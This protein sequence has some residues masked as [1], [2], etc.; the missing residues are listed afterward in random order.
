VIKCSWHSKSLTFLPKVSVSSLTVSLK[1]FKMPDKKHEC[2]FCKKDFQSFNQ[3]SIHMRSHTKESPWKCQICVDEKQFKISSHYY[4]HMRKHDKDKPQVPYVQKLRCT[5]FLFI[6]S[7]SIDVEFVIKSFG[8][9]P[10][11]RVMF[12]ITQ[13][14]NHFPVTFASEWILKHYTV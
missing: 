2:Y 14:K 4:Y 12:P 6:Q 13:T 3:L 9:W 5:D 8:H 7:Q 1:P 10:K 11:W